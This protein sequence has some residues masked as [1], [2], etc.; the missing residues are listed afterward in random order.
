MVKPA[1]NE[2]PFPPKRH[3]AAPDIPLRVIRRYARAVGRCSAWDKAEPA[4]RSREWNKQRRD[5]QRQVHS[6]AK[7]LFTILC[8]SLTILSR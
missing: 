7:A 1:P 4:A 3:Y 5:L 6:L 8:A 2:F